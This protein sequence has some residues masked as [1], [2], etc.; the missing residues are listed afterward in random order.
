VREDAI[1]QAVSLARKGD[2]ILLL[3]KGPEQ[4]IEQADGPKP[5]NEFKALQDALRIHHITLI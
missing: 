5:W 4:T 3:S 2:V 1:S